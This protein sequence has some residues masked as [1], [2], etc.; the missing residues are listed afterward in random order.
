[1][2]KTAKTRLIRRRILRRERRTFFVLDCLEGKSLKDLILSEVNEGVRRL[3]NEFDA[4]KIGLFHRKAMEGIDELIG[5]V[6]R[7]NPIDS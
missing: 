2:P 7:I 3:S 4:E 1:M 6:R 5:L